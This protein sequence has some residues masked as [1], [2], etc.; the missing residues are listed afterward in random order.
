MIFLV[1]R[2]YLDLIIWGGE[3]AL[4]SISDLASVKRLEMAVSFRKRPRV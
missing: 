3:G 4:T 2:V 1:L